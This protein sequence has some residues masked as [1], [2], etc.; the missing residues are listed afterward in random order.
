MTA[1]TESKR[2]R[3]VIRLCLLPGGGSSVSGKVMFNPMSDA[4]VSNSIASKVRWRIL[5]LNLVN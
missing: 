3:V 1:N 5:S 2:V 4:E